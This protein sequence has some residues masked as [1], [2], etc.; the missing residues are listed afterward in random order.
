MII[1][2]S[3]SKPLLFL[4]LV[5]AV[6]AMASA[7]HLCVRFTMALRGRKGLFRIKK[8]HAQILAISYSISFILGAIIYPTFRVRVRYEYFDKEL[9]WATMLFEIKEHYAAIA[10]LPVL[11]L[12][13]I[14]SRLDFTRHEDRHYV[15]LCFCLLVVILIALFYNAVAGWYLGTLRSL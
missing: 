8:M 10:L 7:I 12:Y 9:P 11:A 1:F 15:P 13:V 6:I 4:H 2:E 14:S 3:I 5:T